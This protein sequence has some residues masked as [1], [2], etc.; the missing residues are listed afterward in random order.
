QGTPTAVTIF[1]NNAFLPDAINQ[2]MI[3]EGI[4]SFTFKRMGSRDD[5]GADIRLWDDSEM[6]SFTGGFTLD[7]NNGGAFDGWS[8]EGYFQRGENERKGYQNGLRV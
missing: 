1:Q 3:A 2:T 8:L 7:I 6:L 4:E 5:I